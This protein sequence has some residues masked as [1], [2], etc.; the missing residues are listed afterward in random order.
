MSAGASALGE[1]AERLGTESTSALEQTKTGQH[2]LSLFGNKENELNL[3]PQG[4]AIGGMLKTYHQL[5]SSA[6][7]ESTKDVGAVL[8]WHKNSDTA[9]NSFPLETSTIQQL[10]DHA[11]STQHPI[12]KVTGKILGAGIN[13]NT[14]VNEHADLTLKELSLKNKKTARLTAMAG[15]V[16]SKME[17]VSPLIAS[18]LEHP[19]VRVQM[20]GRAVADIV[21]N[22]LRDTEKIKRGDTLSLQS[23]AKTDINKTFNT[24]NKFRARAG[25]EHS[26]PLLNTDPTT[27]SPSKAEKV[28]AYVLRTVQIPFVAIPHI[29]QY[30]H[31]PMSAPLESIGKALLQMNKEEMTHTIEASGI[32]ANTEW[33]VI[34]SEISARTGLIAKWTN[35]PTAASIIQ[36][37]IHTPGFQQMRLKQLASAGSV[38]YH[39]AIFWAH[40]AVKGDKRAIAELMEMGIDPQDV[41][42]QKGQLTEEQLT[43]GVHHFVNNRFFFDKSIDQALY[44]NKNFFHRSVTMYHSFISSETAYLRRELIKQFKAGDIKGIAQFVG[45][46]G[47]VFPFVAPMIKS[48]ELLARTGSPTQTGA[49]IKH[50]YTA[51]TG[52]ST[53]GDFALTYAD[54]IAH[55]GAMGVAYNYS[56][57]I[58]GHRLANTMMGPLAGMT[59]TDIEDLYG[60][61]SGGTKKPLGRDVMEL[62]PVAGKILGH[63]LFPTRK[64]S[65]LTS[66]HRLTRKRR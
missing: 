56:N 19:D 29:G 23:R 3:T 8:D 59:A 28:A 51:L 61:A 30:F 6:L 36:K 31:L 32:L 26:I 41:I 54:M 40:N 50:D 10:H 48:A 7:G 57:A 55:I 4:K 45:T 9:R 21:S 39:S 62:V 44:S 60:A 42:K 53:F 16:G 25:D 17:N 46:L 34:H 43:R 35:S 14:G 13:P 24:V 49:S 37:T 27:Y 18:M 5:R 47:V 20:N 1:F 11:V 33:D 64:E 2:I 22:E 12:K 58:K 52:Q 63:Q 38:G 15:S 65:G 66:G